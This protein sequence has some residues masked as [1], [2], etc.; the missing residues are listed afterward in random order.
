VT[1]TCKNGHELTPENQCLRGSR[2]CKICK[3]E[4]MKKRWATNREHM[5]KLMREYTERNKVAIR[6]RAREQYK[7]RREK[8]LAWQRQ[9]YWNNR[10]HF[11][12]ANRRWH[13]R[14]TTERYNEILAAQGGR[15]AICRTDQP[16]GRSNKWQVDH[17][18]ACCPNRSKTCGKCI[19][20]LLCGH[21][22]LALGCVQ[23]NIETL[24]S[25]VA[26]LERT[27]A[28]PK[29]LAA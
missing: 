21:C 25:M 27:G 3:R 6:Q 18:H 14:L 4:Y 7:H 11:A 19:R 24:K 28:K 10:E 9:Y 20:G 13:H 26:Y 29:G 12:A 8:I 16:K 23:D 1:E 17:D 22:N 2:E 5:L 15:C